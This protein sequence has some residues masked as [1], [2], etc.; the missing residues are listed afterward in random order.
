[1]ARTDYLSYYL[2]FDSIDGNLYEVQIYTPDNRGY[3]RQLTPAANPFETAEDDDSD[4]FTPMR[5]QTGYLRIVTN[6]T[7]LLEQLMPTNNMEHR[8]KVLRLDPTTKD[9]EETVWQGWMQ[10]ECYEQP[11]GTYARQIEIPLRSM[12]GSLQDQTI[13]NTAGMMSVAEILLSAFPYAENFM[14][15]TPIADAAGS[16]YNALPSLY[17]STA[18]QYT[19]EEVINEGVTQTILTGMSYYELLEKICQLFGVVVREGGADIYIITPD[20]IGAGYQF[21]VHHNL[22]TFRYTRNTLQTIVNKGTIKPLPYV[23]FERKNISALTLRGSDATQSYALGKN[24]VKITLPVELDSLIDASIPDAPEDASEPESVE[25]NATGNT[26]YVKAYSFTNTSNVWIHS[27]YETRTISGYVVVPFR[28]G[29]GSININDVLNQ[30]AIRDPFL[31]PQGPAV[32]YWPD[33]GYTAAYGAFLIRYAVMQTGTAPTTLNTGV[34]LQTLAVHGYIYNTETEAASIDYLPTNIQNIVLSGSHYILAVSSQLSY[35]YSNQ[36]I[37]VNFNL[38]SFTINPFHFTD[39]DAYNRNLAFGEAHDEDGNS[40]NYTTRLYCSLLIIR[41]GDDTPNLFWTGSEWREYLGTSF[42]SEHFTIVIDRHGNIVSNKTPDMQVEEDGGI[43]AKVPADVTGRLY[44]VIWP[45]SLRARW[46]EDAPRPEVTREAHTHIMSNFA[47]K[48]CPEVTPLVSTRSQN[49]YLATDIQGFSEP[50]DIELLYGTKNNNPDSPSFFNIYKDG[51]FTAVEKLDIYNSTIDGT[52]SEQRPE[53]SLL[54]RMKQYYA[55][56]HKVFTLEVRDNINSASRLHPGS[57]VD[58][59][60]RPYLP[61][62]SKHNWR[63]G[64]IRLK[65]IDMTN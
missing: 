37:N 6:D 12:I 38:Q 64:I 41:D 24:K 50:K 42:H 14:I 17:M 1:M 21:K 29:Y 43:F 8:V 11:W 3:T 52:S 20:T 56:T 63:D 36:Y 53:V 34:L 31:R 32:N 39:N 65:L 58:Y 35:N 26:V 47:I 22:R 16:K 48:V 13:T 55:Q 5:G 51:K 23:G 44:F 27:S 45:Y 2:Q 9:E 60:G 30:T 19:K 62:V 57:M 4:L 40:D 7:S 33:T 59:Q 28:S 61:I 25:C 54:N 46:Y 49:V 18:L 15:W 10:A